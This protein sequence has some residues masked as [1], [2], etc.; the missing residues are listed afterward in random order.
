ML[1]RKLI[2]N[3][4]DFGLSAGI[5]RGVAQAHEQGILTSASLMVRWPAASEAAEYARTHPELSVGLHC[6]LGEWTYRSGAWETIYAIVDLQDTK[7]VIAEIAFQVAEFRRLMGC[8]PTHL[9]SHQHVHRTEPVLGAIRQLAEELSVPL[10]H[11]CEHVRYCGDF[12]GQL[13]KNEPCHDAIQ[14]DG[15][16]GILKTIP[17][18]ITE[19]A[20]H[21]GADNVDSPYDLERRIE[22]ATLCHPQIQ[23]VIQSEGIQLCTFRS[24]GLDLTNE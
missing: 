4:D 8:D 13:S 11:F 22:L 15:L 14:V 9:D 20:C 7:A 1:L 6:D 5:N 16:V 2:V 3:A 21:P 24:L 23:K 10:R 17:V 18:G 19:L 12:Y